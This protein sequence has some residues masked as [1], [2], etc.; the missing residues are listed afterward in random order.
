[1]NGSAEIASQA[2]DAGIPTLLMGMPGT[3]KT[4]WANQRAEAK[5]AH[6]ETLIG[7]G[8]DRTDIFGMPAL[9]DG[10]VRFTPPAWARNL[11]EADRQGKPTSLLLDEITCTPE[12]VQ[13]PMLRLVQERRAADWSLPRNTEIILAAN[14]PEIAAGGW[15][16]SV[17][18]ANRIAHVDWH[19]PFDSW[20]EW[21]MAQKDY[22]EGRASIV[23]FL[24]KKQSLLL[25]VPKD[26][27]SGAWPSARSWDHS[28]RVFRAQEVVAALVGTAAAAEYVNWLKAADLP[29]PQDVLTGK[30]KLPDGKQRMDARYACMMNCIAYALSHDMNKEGWKLITDEEK[31]RPDMVI[32]AAKAMLAGS[33]GDIPVEVGTLLPMLKKVQ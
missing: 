7:S 20:A 8:L 21:M 9:V 18:L 27:L 15:D 17:P 1:M 11:I 12:V 24:N 31:G 33:N 30:V 13:A 26:N 22:R 2:L 32:P 5:G 19:L 16:I 3:A 10:Y 28:A 4:A 23:G 29:D 6:I 25:Q 14:P